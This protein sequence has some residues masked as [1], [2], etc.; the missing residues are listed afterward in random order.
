MTLEDL[1]LFPPCRAFDFVYN[2]VVSR[3]FV[4]DLDLEQR[5]AALSIAASLTQQEYPLVPAG[6]IRR[7]ATASVATEAPSAVIAQDPEQ[8][9]MRAGAIRGRADTSAL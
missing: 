1:N 8:I 6:Q 9:G 5:S 7:T 2:R 4:S 3:I